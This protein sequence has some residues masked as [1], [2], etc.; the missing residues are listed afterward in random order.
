MSTI[1]TISDGT[2][3]TVPDNLTVSM[4]GGGGGTI[5]PP[6][7]NPGPTP[8]PPVIGEIY[9]PNQNGVQ[10]GQ[11]SYPL[12]GQLRPYSQGLANN[13]LKWWYKVPTNAK[14]SLTKTGF[15]RIAEY[16]GQGSIGRNVALY[17][18]GVVWPYIRFDP[19]NWNNNP[20][21]NC[22]TGNPL[23]YL[24]VGAIYN[25]QPGDLLEWYLRNQDGASGNVIIDIAD[26]GR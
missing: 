4:S 16:P 14:V 6:N 5:P 24:D 17:I 15:T 18:N 2:I 11:V 23:H 13:V 20:G 9:L 12:N 10:G 25:Q 26:P 3:I 1:V 8:L 19:S 22:T 7:P 21:F